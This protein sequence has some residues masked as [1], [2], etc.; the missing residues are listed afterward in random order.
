MPAEV[1]TVMTPFPSGVTPLTEMMSS[2]SAPAS[3]L[4]SRLPETTVAPPP[5]PPGNALSFT[6]AAT[7]L[8]ATGTSSMTMTLKLSAPSAATKLKA[9]PRLFIP[10][11]GG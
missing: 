5:L 11:P 3:S 10:P 1:T 4:A 9:R 7:S 6:A 2:P 8:F